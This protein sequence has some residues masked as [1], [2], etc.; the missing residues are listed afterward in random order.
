MTDHYFKS[1]QPRFR[2]YPLGSFFLLCSQN[3][4]LPTTSALAQV[5]FLCVLLHIFQEDNHS[6]ALP[7]S[8]RESA[9]EAIFLFVIL[10]WFLILLHHIRV[11]AILPSATIPYPTTPSR[12]KAAFQMRPF[13]LSQICAEAIFGYFNQTKVPYSP[14]QYSGRYSSCELPGIFPMSRPVK[15]AVETRP[16]D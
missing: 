16:E 1:T 11:N 3:S 6:S 12:G 15:D 9:F 5:V 14:V 8:V 2:V 4:I 7:H 10:V 13:F